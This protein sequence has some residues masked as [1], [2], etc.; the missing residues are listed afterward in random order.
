MSTPVSDLVAAALPGYD[1]GAELGRGGFGTVLAARHRL[2]GRD[3]AVKVLLA[4]VDDVGRG[5]FGSPAADADAASDLRSR[6]LAEAR[7][8]AGL[9]HP[10]VVRVYDYVEHA[11]LCLLVMEQL[12][13]GS[14]RERAARGLSPQAACAIG[15]AAAAALEAAHRVGVLHRD[16]K[17]D[18]LLFG[19]DG[20]PRVTDFGIAKIV[21]TTAATA[22]GLLGTPRYMAPEQ[23]EG[24]RLGPGTD[25]YSLGV[26]LYEL[27]TGRTVF[28]R[29]LAVPAL[30]HHH[31]S[32]PP[33]PM[34]EVPPPLAA[35]VLAMLEKDPANRP[36]SAHELAMMLA[37]AATAVFGLGWLAGAGVPV[38]VPEDVLT[39]AGHRLGDTLPVP[40]WPATPAVVPPAYP[41]AP[42]G[43]PPAP[44]SNWH[45]PP[46]APG[47]SWSTPQDSP[48]G[49]TPP[50]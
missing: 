36:R 44:P 27:L 28:P 48:A 13:G 10:H 35:V 25:L 8:L 49:G 6:F 19:A 42:A 14:L 24:T 37:A 20:V 30:M 18:N 26:V 32:V 3:V 23:I 16:I 47:G 12:T 29:G 11:G 7:V 9:D 15:L 34:P 33:Q 38:R 5:A 17:P 43:G 39:A 50:P 21:E 22:T 1:V 2:I 31:L 40:G 41:G 4:D 46:G 45:T